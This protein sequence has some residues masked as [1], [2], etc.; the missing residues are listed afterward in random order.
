MPEL[1]PVDLR[2]MREECQR[3]L[4][5]RKRFY[6]DRVAH[7]QMNRRLADRRIDIMAAV[8]ALLDK[9][10]SERG[11]HAHGQDTGTVDR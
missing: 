4:D 8:V 7:R 9:L 3:E 10:I 11:G 5:L 6:S 1:F 2:D